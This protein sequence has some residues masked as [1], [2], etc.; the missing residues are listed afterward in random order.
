M[1]HNMDDQW[2]Y[3]EGR[4][5]GRPYTASLRIPFDRARWPEYDHHVALVLRYGA[6]WRDGLP[7]PA[8]LRRLQDLEARII[9]TLEGHGALVATE[10]TDATRT[11]HLYIRGGGALM[12]GFRRRDNASVTHDPHWERVAHLSA[13]AARRAPE[14]V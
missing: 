8:E 11:I 10:T 3:M 7:K 1:V 2:L 5:E 13:G 12:E 14:P 9:D 6:N 4:R